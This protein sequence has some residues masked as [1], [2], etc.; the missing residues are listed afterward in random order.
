MRRLGHGGAQTI[1]DQRVDEQL[2]DVVGHHRQ[3]RQRQESVIL[4]GHGQSHQQCLL[5]TGETDGDPC[6]PRQAQSASDQMTQL[7][8]A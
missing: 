4:Y 8:N 1:R 6:L 2:A 7:Q 5:T 3:Y